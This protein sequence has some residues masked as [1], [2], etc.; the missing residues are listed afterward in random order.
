MT[1]TVTSHNS[2]V[3]HTSTSKSKTG[4]KKFPEFS[5]SL[6]PFRG[7]GG[8]VV[9]SAVNFFWNKKKL[10]WTQERVIGT[11]SFLIH[12]SIQLPRV[13]VS[14]VVVW[15]WRQCWSLSGGYEFVLPF[16]LN[17]KRNKTTKRTEKKNTAL[18]FMLCA[19]FYSLLLF[20]FVL[21]FKM[22]MMK[23]RMGVYTKDVWC[24]HKSV[25]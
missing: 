24:A 15:E 7:M 17:G 21:L 9:G 2:P 3:T 5:S 22:M 8:G 13:K 6:I 4:K 11:V 23:K 1:H 20:V 14:P 18:V 12:P 19:S 10:L 16:Y 25:R